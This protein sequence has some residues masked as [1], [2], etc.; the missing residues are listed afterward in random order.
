MARKLLHLKEAADRL[1]RSESQLRWMVH[2]G[3]APP[4]AVIAGRRMFDED[5]LDRWIEEQFDAE[6]G[7]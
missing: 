4:S 3:T 2:N 5:L 1:R 7:G 6:T